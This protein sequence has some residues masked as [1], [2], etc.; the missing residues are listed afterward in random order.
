MNQ[1]LVNEKVIVT[2]KLKR[3]KSFYKIEFIL[4]ILVV[5]GLI[6]YWGCSE[7]DKWHNAQQGKSIMND[8]SDLDTTIAD[9]ETLVVVLNDKA[10]EIPAEENSDPQILPQFNTV[11]RTA[12]GTEYKVDSILNIPSLD[13]KYPVLNYSTN[14]LLKISINKFWGGEPNEVGNYCI[15]GHNYDGKDIFFGKLHKLQN[16]DIVELQD[17]TGRTVQYKVYNSFIVEP[18]DVACT[19]Q[20]TNGKTEMTL[21]TCSE[22]GKT[23]LIVKCRA[24]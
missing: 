4:S 3:K 23:R 18:T 13:I 22:G 21:I 7:F 24:L 16:G 5:M 15:V 6:V 1:I 10:E 17:K 12:S 8:F 11:Y 19:S 2:P 20:L 14:E 9:E